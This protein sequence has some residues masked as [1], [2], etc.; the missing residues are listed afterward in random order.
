MLAPNPPD[1]VPFP[2]DALVERLAAH[3]DFPS[4]GTAVSRVSALA[5]SET[6]TVGE[7]ANLILSDVHLTQKVLR[8]ANSVHFRGTA[9]SI[10]T[11][12]KAIARIGSEQVRL[13]ALSSALLERMP[14]RARAAALAP[15]LTRALH[16]AMLAHAAAVR[17][18]LDGEEAAVCAMFR[19]IGHLL[20][21]VY[22]ADCTDAVA[23]I[24]HAAH[25]DENEA[26]RR[27]TGTTYAEI[28]ERILARWGIPDVIVKTVGSCPPCSQLPAT[29]VERLKLVSQFAA[30]VAGAVRRGSARERAEALKDA[31]ADHGA[32]LAVDAE[33]LQHLLHRTSDRTRQFSDAL[34]IGLADD[35][36]PAAEGAGKAIAAPP[37]ADA[38]I[39][40]PPPDSAPQPDAA[41]CS[42]EGKPCDAPARLLAGIQD[43]TTG[44]AEGSDIAGVLNIAAETL[45]RGMG[46]RRTLICLR[47]V[48]GGFRGRFPFG[49]ID[50]EHLRL[51][52]FEGTPGSDLFWSVLLRNVDV[53]IR[54]LTAAAIASRLPAWFRAACPDAR[55]FVVLP[56]VFRDRP[57]GFFYGDR[58]HPDAPG[59]TAQELSLVR[60]LKSQTLI[61]LRGA[62]QA[63]PHRSHGHA[64]GHAGR[65]PHG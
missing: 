33:A 61:A 57:L 64:H 62:T 39:A 30:N 25:V 37:D 43:M 4:L 41:G 14:D 5:Q 15:E 31:L 28:G 10:T 42:P 34:E 18:G 6:S 9:P 22:A 49:A 20:L 7:L 59:L 50:R 27:V 65:H 60:M 58:P 52:A 13:V 19:S 51:F 23:A 44:F 36:E 17:V 54:D 46:Y 40:L 38:D 29:K 32:A 47:D 45:H 21:T 12:S 63:A 53:H 3:S 11:V 55:S 2:A 16:A 26:A 1:V 24:E 8:L 56:I 48:H 35:S